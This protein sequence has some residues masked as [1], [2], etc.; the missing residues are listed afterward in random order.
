MN[1]VV[2]SKD[3][4]E[5]VEPMMVAL[6]NHDVCLVQ[7]RC[8][9]GCVPCRSIINHSGDGFLAGRM[10]DYGAS[11]FNYSGP[12]LFL[13]GDRIPM[14]DLPD[15]NTFGFDAICLMCEY[16]E[17][18]WKGAGLIPWENFDNP[19]NWIYS[20]GIWLSQAAIDMA[21]SKCGGRIF[22]ESFDGAWGEEDRY[23]GD[24]LV[25]S[26]LTIGYIDSPKLTGCVGGIPKNR[27]NEFEQ[28]F[29][30]RIH[31]RENLIK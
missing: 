14:G 17:R 18:K 31:L 28:N 3:Q 5:N 15:M 26:G 30:K 29:I 23:L 7:D 19:H 16:D 24:V 9:Y 13:D 20:C 4:Q 12:I 10:R 8:D 25:A 11:Y 1:V 21:R 6:R 2:I 22:H 27:Q